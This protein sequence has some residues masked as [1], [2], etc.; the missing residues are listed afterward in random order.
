MTYSDNDVILV[1][2]HGAV[3]TADVEITNGGEIFRHICLTHLGLTDADLDLD[4]IYDTRTAKTVSLAVYLYKDQPSQEII[5]RLEHS[6]Q[7]DS[8]QDAQGRLGLRA[9]MTTAPSDIR[10]IPNAHVFDLSVAKDK[11][12]LYSEVNVYY[13]E[14]P[15]A[16][17]MSR[18]LRSYPAATYRLGI[19][20]S[21]DVDTYLT[22][23][24]D[25]EALGVAVTALIDK[26]IVSFTVSRCL[27]SAM[28][29]E[30]VYLTRTRYFGSSGMANNLLLR[31]LS[32][33]KLCSAGRTEI[34]AEVV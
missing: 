32:I 34:K 10:Y 23:A 16:D 31:L 2:F 19:S 14:D 30:L 18:A 33:G 29:G 20:R 11:E 1:D 24:A 13:A 28:P 9:A 27:F 4:S 3:D 15:K 22:T 8:Y 6:I 25:A 12:S 7:A 5:R 21:L 26:P 17:T